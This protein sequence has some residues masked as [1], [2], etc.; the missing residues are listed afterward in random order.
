M[1]KIHEVTFRF[2]ELDRK[3]LSREERSD[4][5]DAM[6]ARDEAHAPYSGF[7]V[8]A[9]LTTA[10]G[11]KWPGWNVENRVGQGLHAEEGAIGKIRRKSR[12]S[13][14]IRV[15]TVGG[16]RGDER[17]KEP[18]VP[19]GICR[20]KLLELALPDQDPEVLMAGIRGR[21]LK[22][23]LRGLLPL[24]FDPTHFAKQKAHRR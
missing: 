13:G 3:E 14:L 11:R 20:Q 6:E 22:A 5:N 10:D 7:H 16:P 17:Y 23:T 9:M 1:G 4:L 24:A 15:V 12:E 19:C 21:V 8:G 2:E 18:V